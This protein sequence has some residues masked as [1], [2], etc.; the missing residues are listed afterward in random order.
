VTLDNIWEEIY[1]E[2]YLF[3]TSADSANHKPASN[4][5]VTTTWKL[6]LKETSTF[7]AKA[8]VGM[9]ISRRRGLLY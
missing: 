6:Q 4:C 5:Q 9:I 2:F 1:T 3:C 7:R 8:Y